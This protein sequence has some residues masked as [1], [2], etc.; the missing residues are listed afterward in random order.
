MSELI[1]VLVAVLVWLEL[2]LVV[3]LKKKRFYFGFMPLYSI[4]DFFKE[5]FYNTFFLFC[6]AVWSL[7]VFKTIKV[8]FILVT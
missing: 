5:S 1:L 6:F 4:A 2:G 8:I 3:C 7:T